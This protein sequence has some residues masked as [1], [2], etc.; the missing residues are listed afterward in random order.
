MASRQTALPFSWQ[1]PSAARVEVRLASYH[2][3]K[4]S[5]NSGRFPSTGFNTTG[6]L[7]YETPGSPL[8]YPTRF[9]SHGRFCG[10]MQLFITHLSTSRQRLGTYYKR[11]RGPGPESVTPDVRLCADSE[12]Q[13]H[14]RFGLSNDAAPWMP[15]A[16]PRQRRRRKP[17]ASHG[18]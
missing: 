11:Q 5:R 2:G 14:F 7:D 16:G 4:A 12:A 8:M 1:V 6:H 13:L 17:S 15:P 9:V 10:A 3:S 18:H